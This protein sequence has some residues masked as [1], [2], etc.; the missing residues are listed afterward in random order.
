[1]KDYSKGIEHYAMYLPALSTFY[2]NMLAKDIE[3]P[4]YFAGRVPAGLDKGIQGFNYLS[5]DSYFYY[6]ASLYSA[7]HAELNLSKSHL[8]EPMLHFRDKKKTT[9]ICD[10]GGFQI[11]K[12]VIKID[13]STIETPAGDKLREDILRWMEAT[14][15][16]SM[17][18][19]VPAFAATGKLSKKTGL[20]KFEDTLRVSIYNLHY[21]MKHRK[22]GATK[23]L[24]V[25]SGYTN[26]NGREWYHAVKKFSNPDEIEKMGYPREHTI[27][28]FAFAGIHTRNIYAVLERL[29]MLRDDNLLEGKDWIHVLGTGR[30]D[31]SCFLS[32]CQ[33]QIK[34]HYNPNLTI[35]FDAASPFLAT[36]YGQCYNYNHYSNKK[37]MYQMSKVL[38]RKD[39]E[40]CNLPMPYLSPVMNRLTLGDLCPLS[41][42]HAIIDGQHRY[43]VTQ[44]ETEELAKAGINAVWQE[45]KLNRVG[46]SSRTSWD[47]L[48][49]LFYMSHN[50]A[51]HIEATQEA[52]RIADHEYN[53]LKPNWRNW[54]PDKKAKELSDFVPN[55]ILY[56][57]SF[58]EELFDPNTKNHF[59]LLEENRKF[60]ETVS[61]KESSNVF[62]DLFSA[63]DA[64]VDEDDFEGA[65][66]ALEEI[67]HDEL[68]SKD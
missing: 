45:E 1:M 39:L 13:W 50:V 11:A 31:W 18:L 25:I 5:E 46:K 35:S 26:E 38:D 48:S 17:T 34:K 53:R 36:A 29:L 3:D 6:P 43:D 15:D 30:L 28:G 63:E 24:N 65:E 61:V 4:S 64:I 20:T 57:M 23:L 62:D 12:G 66:E 37:F 40:G 22:P 55:A 2:V 14:G 59:E 68:D 56:F 8:K 27:E 67:L 32:A 60:L 7:G 42:A 19:D 41:Q 54:T 58:V 10:S 49:Y 51:K 52:N 21:F 47:T 16:W 9:I 44:E 33:R